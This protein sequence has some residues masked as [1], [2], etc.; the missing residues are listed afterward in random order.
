MY[1]DSGW[2]ML[3]WR[4]LTTGGQVNAIAAPDP[5]DI[6]RDRGEFVTW[7]SP[8]QYLI[9]GVLTLFGLRL[10]SA[11][12]ITAGLSLLCCLLGWIQVFKYFGLSPQTATIAVAFL[13]TF[14]YSTLPFGIYDGG[15]ILLQ[16]LTPWLILAGC[17]VPVTGVFR[18]AALAALAVLLGFLAKL[19]GVLVAVAALAAGALVTLQQLRRITTSMITG[20]A[21]A[22]SVIA[23]LY[24][25]WFSRG[26]TPASGAGW[27]FQL[28]GL[29]YSVA[30]PWGSGVAWMDMLAWLFLNPQRPLLRDA[31]EL[32]WLLFPPFLFF[33]SGILWGLLRGAARH[34]GLN[35]LIRITICFYVICALAMALLYTHGGAISFEERHVRSAGTLIF[36]CAIAVADVMPRRALGRVALLAFCGFMSLYGGLS[37]ITR[38]RSTNPREID[39]YSRTH[40]VI[41]DTRAIDYVRAAFAREGRSALFVLPSPDVASAFPPGARIL[42]TQLD[43]ES[44]AKVATRKYAGR[45]PGHLYIVIQT[46]LDQAAKGKLLL[47]GFT[48]YPL[49]AWE[50][51]Q[52]GSTTV[53]VQGAPVS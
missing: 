49:G 7:W 45:V 2:G 6:S 38:V 24:V 5:A 26:A 29:I 16:G 10:G 47:E 3:E 36:V 34:L 33:G 8:G 4:S 21:G 25:A 19:T 46:R 32:T 44:E 43:F 27:S 50:R 20:A 15:E 31:S 39:H 1:S 28:N 30:A 53:L 13:S 51:H 9:P 35:D 17:V 52:F 42:S 14:R 12:S 37:F 41:V 18:A 11:F 48:N 40:Q 23:F 22:M